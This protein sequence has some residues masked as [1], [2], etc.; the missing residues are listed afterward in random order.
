MKAAYFDP[1]NDG[2]QQAAFQATIR[3]LT[4]IVHSDDINGGAPNA[5]SFT[6]MVSYSIA[7]DSVSDPKIQ[8]VHEI[9]RAHV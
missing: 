9:G 7:P 5:I 1:M 6:P 4:G 8:S 2:P 3:N